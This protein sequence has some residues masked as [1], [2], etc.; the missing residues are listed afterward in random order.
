MWAAGN[1]HAGHPRRTPHQRGSARGLTLLEMLLVVALIA[2]SSFGVSLALRDDAVQ[3]LTRESQRLIALLEAARAQSQA[4]ATVMVFESNATGFVIRT[5]A[6]RQT[7]AHNWLY[8]D[9]RASVIPFVANMVVDTTSS[10]AG[11]ALA[12]PS[13]SALILGPEPILAAQRLRLQNQDQ[14]LVLA[15]DGLRGF[16]VSAPT[17]AR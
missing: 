7:Q 17:P 4:S 11:H 16:E 15:T 8:G 3:R 12:N 1:K 5:P 10:A 14:S 13:G 6:T 9:T 2:L